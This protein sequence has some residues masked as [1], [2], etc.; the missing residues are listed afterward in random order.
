MPGI[1]SIEG[2]DKKVKGR[3]W[4]TAHYSRWRAHGDP[5]I[6]LSGPAQPAKPGKP[7]CSIEGCDLPRQSRGWCGTHYMR[8][9][10][11]GDPTFVKQ[12][13]GRKREYFGCQIEGCE[14]PHKRGGLCGS[15]DWRLRKWG[16]PLAVDPRKIPTQC[17]VEGC[18]GLRRVRG[19]CTLHY[20]RLIN[21]GDPGEAAARRAR[22]GDGHINKD[23]YHVTRGGRVHRAVMEQMLGRPLHDFE[24]VHHI[25]GLRADNRPE[26]LELWVKRQP[27]GQRLADIIA[28]VVTNYRAELE[29]ELAK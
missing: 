7:V 2:C 13:P 9:R 18:D 19:L 5:T 14:R 17:S 4:C 20:S 8:W 3:G 10:I 21:D 28:F 6:C 11:H 27:C 22:A 23:G 15:H 16:D 24:N 29:T 25:N 12:K 1:C 26:N